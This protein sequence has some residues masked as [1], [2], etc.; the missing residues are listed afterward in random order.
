M[1]LVFFVNEGT[2]IATTDYVLCSSIGTIASSGSQP[3]TNAISDV[4]SFICF[5]IEMNSISNLLVDFDHL[6]CQS[7]R[8]TEL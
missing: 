4:R 8:H 2:T 5:S 7:R 1:Y 6:L 3:C